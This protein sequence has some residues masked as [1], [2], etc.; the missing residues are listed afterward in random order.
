MLLS[1]Y[2]SRTDVAMVNL[3][4]G[5]KW[6]GRI[7]YM[8]DIRVMIVHPSV[9][10]M[11]QVNKAAE[12]I[13][14]QSWGQYVP[15]KGDVILPFVGLWFTFDPDNGFIWAPESKG[16][17]FG[18][19]LRWSTTGRYAVAHMSWRSNVPRQIKVG[20]VLGHLA[21]CKALTKHNWTLKRAIWV[22]LV[23]LH[24]QCGFFGQRL[25]ED[26]SELVR[27]AGLVGRQV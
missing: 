27:W 19:E 6:F 25:V 26:Y 9:W 4:L 24:V 12:V 2:K 17:S 18:G 15:I 3:E 21:K 5:T 7:R 16:V 8:D 13:T 14:Y 10:D 22:H 23:M 11:E 20:C 1:W